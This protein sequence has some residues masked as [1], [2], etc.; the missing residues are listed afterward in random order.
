M[1]TK[2]T[3]SPA[4]RC[5]ALCK[6]CPEMHKYLTKLT[7]V[8]LN[9]RRAQDA[10]KC[11]TKLTK[12]KTNLRRTQTGLWSMAKLNRCEL[13]LSKAVQ[14]PPSTHCLRHYSPPLYRWAVQGKLTSMKFLACQTT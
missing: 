6:V 7:K 10:Q 12:S 5:T 13:N 1:M 4:R 14:T 8:E 2:M 3:R 9:T 11:V